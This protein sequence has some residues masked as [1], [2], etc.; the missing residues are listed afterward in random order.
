[1][2]GLL[3]L[4][5]LKIPGIFQ[6][7]KCDQKFPILI[8][9]RVNPGDFLKLITHRIQFYFSSEYPINANRI[10]KNKRDSYNCHNQH[11]V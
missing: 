3:E 4:M 1:M 8:L 6:K 9:T 2:K 11:N 5:Q 7:L 10:S